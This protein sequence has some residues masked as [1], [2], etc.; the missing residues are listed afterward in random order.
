M[1]N[2]IAVKVSA[3][4]KRESTNAKKPASQVVFAD[5]KKHGVEYLVLKYPNVFVQT[6]N[7]MCLDTEMICLCEHFVL[8]RTSLLSSYWTD[9]CSNNMNE[10][11]TDETRKKGAFEKVMRSCKNKI[12]SSENAVAL[13]DVVPLLPSPR[14]QEARQ[15]DS[16]RL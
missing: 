8:R 10:H 2:P 11:E 14:H 5:D 7:E 4:P 6:L 13:R 3:I 15:H 12:L 1:N 9:D 16:K